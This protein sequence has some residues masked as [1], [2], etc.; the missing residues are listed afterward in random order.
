MPS[1]FY[2][3]SNNM[4]T[5]GKH[6]P[7]PIFYKIQIIIAIIA[8]KKKE[9]KKPKNKNWKKCTQEHLRNALKSLLLQEKKEKKKKAVKHPC[10][11]QFKYTPSKS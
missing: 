5:S 8:K 10:P 2:S 11:K 6:P 9:K 4:L 7:S 3:T 1:S